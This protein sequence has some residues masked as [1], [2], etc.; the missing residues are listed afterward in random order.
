M[1][2]REVR[3]RAEEIVKST[4]RMWLALEPLTSDL[5]F[6]ADQWEKDK[7]SGFWRRSVIRCL[8]VALES[9]VWNLKNIVPLVAPVSGVELVRE[10]LEIISEIRTITVNGKIE[11]RLK[12][13]NFKDNLKVTFKLFYK[14]HGLCYAPD[15]TDGFNALCQTYELRNRLMHTKTVFDSKVS[16]DEIE[17]ARL[18]QKWF[19]CEYDRLIRDCSNAATTLLK[20]WQNR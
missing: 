18:G 11:Q 17:S 6:A 14:V 19:N 9:L 12:F 2:K 4:R 15:Y 3:Q 20:K 5:N 7:E 10:E 16:D 13:L 8:L 1:K